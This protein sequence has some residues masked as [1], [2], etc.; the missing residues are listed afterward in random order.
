MNKITELFRHRLPKP[1]EVNLKELNERMQKAFAKDRERHK[2]LEEEIKGLYLKHFGSKEKVVDE[3]KGIEKFLG[4]PLDKL[5][6]SLLEIELQRA[7]EIER[8]D[9]YLFYLQDRYYFRLLGAYME[10]KNEA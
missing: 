1:R 2:K 10:K 6:P 3:L 7:K 4:Q 9:N 8:D 5:M